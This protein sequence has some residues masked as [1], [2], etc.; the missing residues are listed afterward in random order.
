VLIVKSRLIAHDRRSR[1]DE[2]AR[3]W[4]LEDQAQALELFLLVRRIFFFA[5]QLAEEIDSSSR[6]RKSRAHGDFAHGPSLFHK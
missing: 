5:K 6:S 4:V 1:R 3:G 2:D